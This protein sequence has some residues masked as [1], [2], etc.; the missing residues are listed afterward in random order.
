MDLKQGCRNQCLVSSAR[1]QLGW[2][3]RPTNADSEFPMKLVWLQCFGKY[4]AAKRMKRS[5]GDDSRFAPC[6]GN[7][8]GQ[9]EDLWGEVGGNLNCFG[10]HDLSCSCKATESKVRL[11]CLVTL[12]HLRVKKHHLLY[13][14]LDKRGADVLMRLLSAFAV[15]GIAMSLRTLVNLQTRWTQEV[16]RDVAGCSSWGD[17]AGY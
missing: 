4:L 12:L 16:S 2:C 6:L 1:S 10:D 14:L 11:W 5:N 17:E 13:L 15:A 3:K 8:E 7:D 9:R